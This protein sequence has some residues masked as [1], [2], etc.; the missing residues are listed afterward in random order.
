MQLIRARLHDGIE[1]TARRAS[2]FRAELVLQ[3]RNFSHGVVRD[4]RQRSRR[5]MVVIA[6]SIQIERVVLGALAGN[7]RTRALSHTAIGCD[8]G[9][10]K[11]QIPDRGG[12]DRSRL[13]RCKGGLHLRGGCVER[14]SGRADLDYGGCR[15][16]RYRH[17]LRHGV[18]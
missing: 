13:T 15:S 9:S 12:L 10:Q 3:H 14:G 7:G 16:H 6:D 2:E 18:V 1:H 5:V 4:D 8:A 11:R 17:I